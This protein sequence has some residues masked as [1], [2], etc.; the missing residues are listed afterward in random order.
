MD[1]P[2]DESADNTFKDIEWSRLSSEFTNVGY[3]E[4]IAAGKETALQDGFDVGFS[5]TGAPIGRELGVLR[6]ISSAILALLR[7]STIANERES[8]QADAQEI[9]LRLSNI[10]FSDIMPCDL[11]A[12]EQACQHLEEGSGDVHKKIAAIEESGT[13]SVGDVHILKDR[14]KVLSN[15]LN[16]HIDWS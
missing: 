13:T 8:T 4:G 16:L 14:L 7:S 11:E 9:S 5:G 6:G 1:S 15:H 2:W 12:E 10:R 3:R